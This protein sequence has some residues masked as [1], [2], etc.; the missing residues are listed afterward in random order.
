[1]TK[2][3]TLKVVTPTDCEIVLTRVFDAP[4]QMVF[5]ALT[6]PELLSAP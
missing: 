1:M 3:G 5:D 2:T 4:G 6:K